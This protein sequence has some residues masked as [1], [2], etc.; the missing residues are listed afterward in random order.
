MK[1]LVGW[2]VPILMYAFAYSLMNLDF[3]TELGIGLLFIFGGIIS[4]IGD[5]M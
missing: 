5:D 3:W 1:I 2:V 4:R